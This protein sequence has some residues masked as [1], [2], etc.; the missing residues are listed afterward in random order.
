MLN[1]EAIIAISLVVASVGAAGFFAY[2]YH[3]KRQQ[4][5][6]AWAGAWVLLTLHYIPSLFDALFGVPLGDR[7][8]SAA[9]NQ[10]LLGG[11]AILFL[12]SARHY[13]Q[14]PMRAWAAALTLAALAGWAAAYR[15]EAIQVSP[16]LGIALLLF[17]VARTFWY[18]SRKQESTADRLLALVFVGWGVLLVGTVFRGTL[19]AFVG[20]E[21]RVLVLLPQLFAA[22][23]MVMALYE[24]EKRRVERN[25]LALSNL[26]LATSSFLGGEVQ[27]MLGQALD[28]V[29]S[30]VRIPSG[31]LFLK[32][33]EGDSP[34]SLVAAGLSDAFCAAVRK[35]ALDEHLVQVVARLGG[36]IVFRPATSWATLE[37]EDA[38]RRF[39]ELAREENLRAV[40]G[41]SL[42]AKE[43]VFGVLLLGTPDNRRF[44]PAELR[45]LLALGHQIGMAI[46]NSYLMQQTS[47]RTEELHI[48]N[49]IGRALSSTLDL[50]TL[51]EKI[52]SELQ[53]LFD[54][55]N[56][57]IAFYNPHRDE[58]R[59]ELE[60]K[61]NVRATPRSRPAGNRL[62]EYMIRTRQPVLIRE[63]FAEEVRKLGVEVQVDT[64]CFCGVPLV[65][66]DRAIGAMGVHSAQER[67]F[68]EAHLELMRVLASQAG[69]AIEN[70]RLFREEQR[71]S[72]QLNLLNNMSRHAITT[73]NPDEMLAEVVQEMERNL[74]YSHIGLGILDYTSKEIVIQ[75]EG[76][77][78]RGA[79][80]RRI[81]LG[82]GL[83]GTVARSGQMASF[84]GSSRT[85][86]AQPVLE[87]SQSG[88]ALPVVYADQLLG[89]LYVETVEPWE[90]I[91]EEILLLR[92]LADQVA[93]A[94]HNALSFQ[95]A[96]EQAITDGLT[97]VKTH[98]FFM[99]A[100][101]AEWKRS[102][103]GGRPFSLVMVDLDHFKFVNDFHGHLAGDT[104]L[105]RIGRI[106]EQNCRR[107]DVVARYG[108]DE[109]VVLM[110]ETNKEQ[111]VQLAHKL[112]ACIDGDPFLH[113]KNITGSFGVASFPAHGST[114]QELIQ[115]ADSSMYVSKHQGGNAVSTADHVDPREAQK[116]KRDVLE[117]YLGVTLK[118]LFSTGPEAFD[119]IYRRLEQFTQ[120]LEQN[121][122]MADV[123][124]GDGKE[125]T[126]LS[127][128]SP[129]II[130]TI[131]SLAF[132]IDAKDHYTQGHSQKVASYAVL[133][134]EALVAEGRLTQAELEEI[135]LA[136]LLHDVGKVGIPESILNKS[137]P[138]DGD[139]WE[140]MKTHTSLGARV[141]EPLRVMSALQR[142]IK[143]HHEFFDGSGYPDQLKGAEIP[144]GA[145]LV[146]IAD[147]FDTITS[148]RTYKKARTSEDALSE[149]QRCAGAQF[150]PELV[151]LFVKAM[152]RKLVTATAPPMDQTPA[153]DPAP[154]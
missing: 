63:R 122:E 25:M 77:K 59:F 54:V 37:Q 133:L 107:S 60:V 97:A 11:A 129:A 134:A 148:D 80:N 114:P 52:F 88:I 39:R 117:A 95:K 78:R 56:F 34:P 99:E 81:A 36:L 72:R 69:I 42:Q 137:G 38:F 102:T 109:F 65:L 101:A 123:A 135:R 98:R 35:E 23:L 5:L 3:L 44:T 8:W 116:W 53:R 130:E 113:A 152:R 71:K 128:V 92:T 17:V 100:L 70:A 108:G 146:A 127:Q 82:E 12:T 144:F 4:Y 58:I 1:H 46:E 150:D 106:L 142:I 85:G 26:N 43:R 24:E 62:T 67:V 96:Q 93:G 104:V 10:L 118:R 55:T 16:Y 49:E 47:R 21:V 115:V 57:Y 91:E 28:R 48:L 68:D 125:V 132:A 154:R 139:E 84:R 90:F 27:K 19:V 105:Q 30:V 15:L 41:I 75:A 20:P 138:L 7:N 14:L 22:V 76:G 89:V 110:P 79:L 51:F 87:G 61:D 45:L 131:T 31:V 119:E 145:R 140:I 2:I 74:S 64:G 94:L 153:T 112:R 13:A 29:L 40:V 33:A 147:A 120:S 111:A 126:P 83:V 73:L 136:A 86:G 124:V 151:S 121:T 143:H 149:L 66:Y 6:L 141:L 9:L 18:E 50:E 103:R 32:H